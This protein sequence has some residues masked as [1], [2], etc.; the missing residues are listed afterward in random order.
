MLCSPDFILSMHKCFMCCLY[1]RLFIGRGEALTL[2]TAG[3]RCVGWAMYSMFASSVGISSDH[4]VQR[5]A[6]LDKIRIYHRRRKQS[7]RYKR[8]EAELAY[9]AL[10]DNQKRKDASALK[11]F[12]SYKYRKDKGVLTNAEI[13]V[14]DFVGQCEEKKKELKAMTQ[15]QLQ[16]VWT[17]GDCTGLKK[18]ECGWISR[19]KHSSGHKT[20]VA[21]LTWRWNSNDRAG[22][23]QCVVCE[24]S[25]KFKV[26]VADSKDA[27]KH[28][29]KHA[30][31][32]GDDAG[33]EGEHA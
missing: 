9:Q 6:Q 22:L 12:H 1:R 31:G 29:A 26:L 14:D 3:R 17:Q 30:E 15:E 8:R 23:F 28:Q 33:D 2:F 4:L 7:E 21:H 27:K 5:V 32:D 18:C 24:V 19:G 20:S 13:D 11:S 25:G 16:A 10:A